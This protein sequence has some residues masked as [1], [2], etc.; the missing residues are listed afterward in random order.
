M[1]AAL[2]PSKAS[3]ALKVNPHVAALPPYN[4][5]MSLD[6]ARALSGH[7]DLARLASNENPDGCSP[8]VLAALASGG[9][10]PWRYADPACTTLRAA[11]AQ[12]LR[13]E[14]DAIVV[15]N[16]SEEM[17]AAIARSVLVE[18]AQVVTVV[19]SFGLHEIEPLAAGATVL[20]VPMTAA[21]GFD[22]AALEAAIAAGPRVVFLSS[23]WNPVGPAL[24]AAAL[25]R[26]IAAVQP[27]TLFV[28]D[29]A[30]FEYADETLP[31]GVEALRAFGMPVAHV[32]L[33]AIAV[34]E[35]TSFSHVSVVGNLTRRGAGG[36]CGIVCIWIQKW[37]LPRSSPV[38]SASLT[39]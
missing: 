9:F 32:V 25:A 6:K 1:T 39:R 12:R 28:L 4:A 31:D 35:V 15:G 16:G 23:P 21:A 27:G 19:P 20:K 30:Y 33:P 7:Q 22:L 36:P 17:I 24:D 37:T 26:L 2:P 11:L 8:A 3:T 18:A 14:A 5:G 34:G 13:V 29:E 10:E 38:C